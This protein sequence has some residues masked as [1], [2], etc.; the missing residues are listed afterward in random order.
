MVHQLR[1]DHARFIDDDQIADERIVLFRLNFP[2]LKSISSKLWIVKAFLPVISRHPLG[3]SSRRSR[4]KNPRGDLFR[5]R[6]DR[7]CDRALSRSGPPVM[8]RSFSFTPCHSAVFCSGASSILVAA[9][10]IRSLFRLDTDGCGKETASDRASSRAMP[11][12]V[13][14]ERLDPNDVLLL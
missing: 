5:N 8:I 12:S 3:G 4:E 1:V 14:I 2:V 9:A 11:I 10:P 6:Q 7:L 13:K